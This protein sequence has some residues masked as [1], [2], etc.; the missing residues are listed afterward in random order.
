[1]A[2][3]MNVEPALDYAV[4]TVLLYAQEIGELP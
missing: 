3:W 1:V 4:P 2:Y